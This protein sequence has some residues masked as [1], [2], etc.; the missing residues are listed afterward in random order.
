MYFE[1][2]D[3]ASH[4]FLYSALIHDPFQRL[5]RMALRE[6]LLMM[7]WR[8]VNSHDGISL[9]QAQLSMR[10]QSPLALIVMCLS[11]VAILCFAC[12]RLGKGK[13]D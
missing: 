8:M 12:R 7:N 4:Y 1:A 6:M 11:G 13:R 10:R 2:E 3:R 5:R 9:F